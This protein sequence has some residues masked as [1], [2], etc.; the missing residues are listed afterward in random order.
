MPP[1]N[2]RYAPLDEGDIDMLEI[3]IQ[4]TPDAD[5]L[6]ERA[7]LRKKIQ[8]GYI[9][10][11]E[12]G[13]GTHPDLATLQIVEAELNR[14]GGYWPNDVG[15]RVIARA[16]VPL[17]GPQTFDLIKRD[18]APAPTLAYAE[19]PAMTEDEITDFVREMGKRSNAELQEMYGHL[20]SMVEVVLGFVRRTAGV[21][22]DLEKLELVE[23]AKL[24]REFAE[25]GNTAIL[26]GA[27]I[28]SVIGVGGGYLANQPM[29][30]AAVVG[31][32]ASAIAT[33]YSKWWRRIIGAAEPPD[34]KDYLAG[35]PKPAELGAY[36]DE[37]YR[38]G[39][40]GDT[41]FVAEPRLNRDLYWRR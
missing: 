40:V 19:Q 14:R 10:V 16:D 37:P 6:A 22:P 39:V 32:L 7:R 36:Q 31:G 34:E 13:S 41:R 3:E 25:W 1:L 4:Q 23:Q 2:M 30:R 33:R 18:P 12:P 8:G 5:L 26:R 17:D 9:G 35:E 29:G 24:D 15:H 27:L 21:H 11:R 38:L 20:S 28:G